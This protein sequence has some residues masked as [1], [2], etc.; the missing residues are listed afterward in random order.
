MTARYASGGGCND[1]SVAPHD[2][3]GFSAHLA[4][5]SLSASFILLQK[6]L[7]ETLRR[8]VSD[9]KKER[10]KKKWKSVWRSCLTLP[11][12]RQF[13]IKSS[14]FSPSPHLVSLP[15]LSNHTCC[16]AGACRL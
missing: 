12:I 4:S 9:T 5:L 10:E 16:L 2:T 15:L 13:L 8:S 14:L 6:S 11:C 7:A 1:D 3:H